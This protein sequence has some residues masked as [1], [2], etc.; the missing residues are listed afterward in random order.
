VNILEKVMPITVRLTPEEEAR[1]SRL[2]ERTGHKRSYH[3]KQALAAYLD[4]MEDLYLAE[5][6]DLRVRAGTERVYTLAEV[7]AELGLAD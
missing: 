2:A 6:V 3:V 1:L 4:D 5:Q 7:S